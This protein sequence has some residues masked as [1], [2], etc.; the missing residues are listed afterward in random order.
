M[1]TQSKK[2]QKEIEK[3]DKWNKETQ[4]EVRFYSNYINNHIN[5]EWFKTT[6]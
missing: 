4:Q 1:L 2:R 3:K 5:Y 6:V